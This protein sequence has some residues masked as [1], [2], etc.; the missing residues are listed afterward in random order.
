MNIIIIWSGQACC[1]VFLTRSMVAMLALSLEANHYRGL[2]D[3]YK[4]HKSTQATKLEDYRKHEWL[5]AAKPRSYASHLIATLRNLTKLTTVH[6]EG[7][8]TIANCYT[9]RKPGDPRK[10]IKDSWSQL[11]QKSQKS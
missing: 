5:V 6:N 9:K 7:A 10:T 11:S 2:L 1:T 3:N 4:P 8:H